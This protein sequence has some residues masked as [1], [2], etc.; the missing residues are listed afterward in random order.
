[1]LQLLLSMLE[2]SEPVDSI[3]LVA[4]T[5]QNADSSGNFV[6]TTGVYPLLLCDANGVNDSRGLF[7]AEHAVDI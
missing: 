1:M 4:F 7:K 3:I 6:F 5:L 2:L